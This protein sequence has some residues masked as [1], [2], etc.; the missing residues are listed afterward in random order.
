LGL[1]LI[2]QR[3]RF[4]WSA[5]WPV[6]LLTFIAV[7]A[8]LSLGRWQW[9]RAAEKRALAAQFHAGAVQLI[10]ITATAATTLPRYSHVRV[11][12]RYD[13]EHQ[14]LLDNMSH[15]GYPG[16]QVLTPL[17]LAD[18]RA[19]LVNRGWV[20]LMQSRRE[21]PHID[22]PTNLQASATAVGLLDNLPV[23]ALAMGHVPPASQASW[24]KLTSFPT[25]TDLSSALGQPLQAR[26]LLL[27]SDQPAGYVRDW[28]PSGF[29]PMQHIA[30]A[31]QWWAFAALALA[32]YAMLNRRRTVERPADRS[33][34]RARR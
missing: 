29:G 22:I 7:V 27:D 14:F 8:F 12:G 25:M 20:P 2:V 24:P 1:P 17:T 26:Q 9:H 30:Y 4:R 34:S 16:F 6:T 3:G 5:S 10:D 31:I 33:L 21:S 15:G 28:K 23:A 32:L 13:A 18:G 19:I 11:V